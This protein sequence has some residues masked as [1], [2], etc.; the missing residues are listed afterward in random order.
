MKNYAIE[1]PAPQEFPALTALWERSVRKK[2]DPA[3]DMLKT[4]AKMNEL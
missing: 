4:N 3:P 1:Q 2:T